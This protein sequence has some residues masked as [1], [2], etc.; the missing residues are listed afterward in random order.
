MAVVLALGKLI[1]ARVISQRGPE[2]AALPRFACMNIS[3]PNG[4]DSSPFCHLYLA[5]GIVSYF[6][7]A[8]WMRFLS[9]K[10]HVESFHS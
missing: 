5:G 4:I 9:C 1:M 2:D 7:N 10:F 3:L 8:V 6:L